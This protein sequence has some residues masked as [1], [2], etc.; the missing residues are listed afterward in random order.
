MQQ[1][2]MSVLARLNVR[3]PKSDFFVWLGGWFTR[4]CVQVSDK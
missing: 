2:S 3:M 4:Y 1:H